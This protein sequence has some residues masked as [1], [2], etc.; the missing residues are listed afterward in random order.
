MGLP[1][2]GRR[3]AERPEAGEGV[4]HLHIC[5]GAS[6]LRPWDGS[7]G[8]EGRDSVGNEKGKRVWKGLRRPHKKGKDLGLIP[9]MKW[10]AIR[11]FGSKE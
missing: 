10:E 7:K 9:K 3:L 4:G 1:G 11:E 5:G 6:L 8:G 2:K